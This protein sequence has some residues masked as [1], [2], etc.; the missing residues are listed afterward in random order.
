MNLYD[1]VRRGDRM[2]DM[3]SKGIEAIEPKLPGGTQRAI[4]MAPGS[5]LRLRA[6]DEATCLRS[7]PSFPGWHSHAAAGSTLSVWAEGADGTRHL[8]YTDRSTGRQEVRLDW[9]VPVPSQFDLCLA[10]E[11]EC[12]V[13]IGPLFNAK[14]KLL[15]M[16][17]GHGV[18]V[19]PGAN[20]SV[21]ADEGRSVRYVERMPMEQW[22]KTYAK[23]PLDAPAAGH[24]SH[25]VVD[26]AHR[27]AGFEDGSIDF[28]FS[29]HVLEHLVNPLQVLRNWWTKLAPGGVIAGVVPDARFTFDLRQP[30]TTRADLLAQVGP[31]SDDTAGTSLSGAFGR[32]ARRLSRKPVRDPF[33]TTDAMYERWCRYTSPENTPASLRQREYSIHVNYFSP[34]SFR[35]LLDMFAAEAS[36]AGLFIESVANGKDFGFLVAKA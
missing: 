25:Y 11:G 10:A 35:L 4:R 26:S 30:L 3:P 31:P 20:P 1:L 23:R 15:P 34:E 2:V 14:A 19:G 27:L 9:P 6:A 13:S 16:L 22:A 32:L 28:V 33:E 21:F 17:R 7:F 8:L 12:I 29:S 5:T 18:E 36:P 24:W